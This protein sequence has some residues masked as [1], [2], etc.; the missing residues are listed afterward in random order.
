MSAWTAVGG[1]LDVAASGAAGGVP[2]EREDVVGPLPQRR[3]L[4][5]GVDQGGQRGGDVLEPFGG[6]G[7]G[8]ARAR[9]LGRRV[10]PLVRLRRLRRLCR[11]GRPRPGH[12]VA[13]ALG[14]PDGQRLDVSDHDGG[15]G[16]AELR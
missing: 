7:E 14:R 1:D 12:E 15:V 5:D 9:R 6:D 8:H 3:Y 13:Q 11:L 16:L 2:G 10:V 4:D